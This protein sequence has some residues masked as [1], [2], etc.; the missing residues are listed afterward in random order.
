VNGEQFVA[1]ATFAVRA[2]LDGIF[3]RLRPWLALGGG[4]SVADYQAPVSTSLPTGA[5]AVGPAGLVQIVAGLAVAVYDSFEVGLHGEMDLTFSSQTADMPPREPFS[6]GFGV[7]AL[8]L[9]FRF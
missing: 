3:G 8:D 9:G 1:H 4:L 2:V 7:L 5:G 6:P